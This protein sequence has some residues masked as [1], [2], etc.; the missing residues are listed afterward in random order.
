[1]A[2]ERRPGL[3]RRGLRKA[4]ELGGRL[5]PARPS[6]QSGRVRFVGP[7]GLLAEADAEAGETL[8]RVAIVSRL[9]LSHYCGGTCSCA[10][11]RVEIV[12]GAETLSPME[13]REQM[14]L[15]YQASQ[16][17]DRLACQARVGGDVVVRIPED[18]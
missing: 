15:G 11:C 1:M 5:R 7:D 9:D 12:E 18:F 10:T 8:L 17:G 3:L 6:A 13:G 16:A 14:V 2:D 4:R